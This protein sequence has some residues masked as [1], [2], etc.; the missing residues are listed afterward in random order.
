MTEGGSPKD[1]IINMKSGNLYKQPWDEG[2]LHLS[3]I[4]DDRI[5]LSGT[6]VE[7]D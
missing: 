4:S 1:F 7:A 6:D 2:T 3:A 5:I